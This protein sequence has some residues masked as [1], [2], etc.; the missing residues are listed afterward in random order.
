MNFVADAQWNAVVNIKSV[1]FV[2]I[3]QKKNASLKF[4]LM[5]LLVFLKRVMHC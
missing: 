2:Y 4:Y 3:M 1:H 5:H